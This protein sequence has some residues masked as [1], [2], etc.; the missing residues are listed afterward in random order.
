VWNDL[1]DGIDGV[2]AGG[3]GRVDGC[4]ADG[5]DGEP[6]RVSARPTITAATTPSPASATA[7]RQ[8]AGPR[9]MSAGAGLEHLGIAEVARPGG[10]DPG[11]VGAHPLILTDSRARQAASV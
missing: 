9:T 8:P 11:I 7:S 1:N 4:D 5:C 6:G 3:S 10:V 2:V